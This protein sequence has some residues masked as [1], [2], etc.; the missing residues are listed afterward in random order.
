MPKV[1]K[2]LTWNKT[3]FPL[4]SAQLSKLFNSTIRVH[5]ISYPFHI[6]LQIFI[7]R[8]TRVSFT[9]FSCIFSSNPFLF[10]THPCKRKRRK[11][12]YLDDDGSHVVEHGWGQQGGPL[13]G[14]CGIKERSDTSVGAGQTFSERSVEQGRFIRSRSGMVMMARRDWGC[15]R[16][17]ET[18][19]LWTN[20][21]YW[22]V[23]GMFDT[24]K[25]NFVL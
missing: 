16:D 17:S 18:S 21:V 15:E 8:K 14:V 7:K 13:F 2:Q 4:S 20:R 3:N 1:Q 23:Q 19:K 22:K 25:L 6:T 10:S 11:G 12:H 24:R 5:R 9:H